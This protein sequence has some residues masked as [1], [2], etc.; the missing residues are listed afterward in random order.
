MLPAV[1]R[2]G[3][4]MYGTLYFSFRIF[5]V[6]YI[7]TFIEAAYRWTIVGVPQFEKTWTRT[8]LP[9][10]SRGAGSCSE[11]W[12]TIRQNE[13]RYTKCRKNNYTY[14]NYMN[15]VTC[16][17]R[18]MSCALKIQATDSNRQ[19]IF[20][21]AIYYICYVVAIFNTFFRNELAR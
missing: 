3:K 21:N 12:S 6:F 14:I 15:K 17:F 20:K 1:L 9:T 19:K 13:I 11:I 16:L 4:Y 7:S 8:G 10:F 18:Y 2:F 5:M